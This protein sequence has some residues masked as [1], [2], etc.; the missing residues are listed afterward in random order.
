MGDSVAEVKRN[1][2]E[3]YNLFALD[4]GTE[5]ITEDQIELKYARYQNLILKILKK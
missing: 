3:A 1:I 2:V 5:E 4:A